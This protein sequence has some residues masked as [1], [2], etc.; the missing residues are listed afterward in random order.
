MK[1]ADGN[2]VNKD[3]SPIVR[4]V[5]KERKNIERYLQKQTA[6]HTSLIENFANQMSPME[7]ECR[8]AVTIPA[9]LEGKNIYTIA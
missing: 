8:V 7:N 6:E 2:W 5:N 9:Y 3:G 4:D 1:N